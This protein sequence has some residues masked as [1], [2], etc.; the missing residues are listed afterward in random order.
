MKPDNVDILFTP[1]PGKYNA[2]DLSIKSPSWKIGQTK[3]ILT[4]VFQKTPGC[5]KYEYKSFI[6]EGR[7]EEE[8]GSYMNTPITTGLLYGYEEVFVCWSFAC[9]NTLSCYFL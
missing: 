4:H 5:G 3:R 1:S 2:N 9:Y 8:D 6:G 7:S